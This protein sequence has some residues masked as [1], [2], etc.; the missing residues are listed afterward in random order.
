MKIKTIEQAHAAIEK[1]RSKVTIEHHET[2]EAS[3][4]EAAIAQVAQRESMIDTERRYDAQGNVTL[5]DQARSNREDWESTRMTPLGRR[6][7]GL[8]R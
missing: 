5:R 2:V 3:R 8:D 7:A 1:I 6:L 4:I